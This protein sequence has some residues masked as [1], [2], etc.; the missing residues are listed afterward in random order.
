MSLAF[1]LLAAI[2][3]GTAPLI[4]THLTDKTGLLLFPAFYMIAFGLLA[5][6]AALRL[7]ANLPSQH[8]VSLMPA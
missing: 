6:P 4:C 8:N 5:L 3:G 2:F 1:T 7:K